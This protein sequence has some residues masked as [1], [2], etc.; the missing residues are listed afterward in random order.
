M[1]G[2]PPAIIGQQSLHDRL[3]AHAVQRGD[4]LLHM[5][6]VKRSGFAGIKYQGEVIGVHR[7]MWMV[8]HGPIPPDMNVVHTCERLNCIHEPHLR[9]ATA[10]IRN[11][12]N[13][14]MREHAWGGAPRA[15]II[16]GLLSE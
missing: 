3:L 14:A 9:L 12:T 13:V 1:S 10:T 8:H 5:R 2:A 7:A 15:V 11:Q 6:N 16:D 4:C